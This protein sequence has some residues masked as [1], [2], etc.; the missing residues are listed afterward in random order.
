[1][2]TTEG[3]SVI[4]ERREMS[5]DVHRH[6]DKVILQLSRDRFVMTTAEAVRLADRLHDAAESKVEK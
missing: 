6:H 2:P 3:D 5:G 1:M 4:R